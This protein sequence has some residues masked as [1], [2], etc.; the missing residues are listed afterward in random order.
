MEGD[1]KLMI[2]DAENTM[3]IWDRYTNKKWRL[4]RP[5]GT[6]VEI[7]DLFTADVLYTRYKD[8]GGMVLTLDS[9]GKVRYWQLE[10]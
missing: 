8:E 7:F 4:Q 1:R 6:M 2:V 9:D 10:E 5:K 3:F